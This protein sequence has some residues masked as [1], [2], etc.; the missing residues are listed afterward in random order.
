MHAP[1]PKLD[2]RALKGFCETTIDVNIAGVIYCLYRARF[3]YA[4]MH[5]FAFA[6]SDQYLCNPVFGKGCGRGQTH[7]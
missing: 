1:V 2:T 3:P 6:H 7:Y 4:N 5:F